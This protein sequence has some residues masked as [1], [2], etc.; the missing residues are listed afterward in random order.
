MSRAYL[1]TGEQTRFLQ[2]VKDKVGLT[3]QQM[4]SICQINRRT[5]L[6]WRKERYH[7]SYR[8]LLCLSHL[9]GIPMPPVIEIVSEKERRRRAGVKGAK[10]SLALY[11]N[12]GTPESR[13]KGG[14]TS[15]RRRREHPEWYDDNF[16][17]RK[18]IKIPAQSL[19][20]AELV[21]ILLGDGHITNTQVIVYGNLVTEVEYS[22]FVASLFEHLFGITASVKRGKG[23]TSMVI[24]S[25]VAL[26]EYLDSIGL[27]RGDKI[28][29]QVSVPS[30]IFNERAYIRA[31]VRGL[32]DT[33]GSVYP[34]TKVYQEREYRYINLCFTTHSQPLAKAMKYMLCELGFRPTVSSDGQRVYLRRQ[35]EVKSYFNEVGT[36]N[37]YHQGRY[38]RLLQWKLES[39]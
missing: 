32:M 27:G 31:C 11:G 2:A 9:S 7:M 3:W 18:P 26:V 36:N 1:G 29:R 12:P 21:G 4:A 38:H 8:A 30:W 16:I 33:D 19:E 13:R 10:K 6:D 15:L 20:L 17:I 5:L 24:V 34:E 25:A 14:R 35:K 28:A 39:K 23:N 22:R 37:P